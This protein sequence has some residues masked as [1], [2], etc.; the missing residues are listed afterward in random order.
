MQINVVRHR[1]FVQI[2][3]VRHRKFVQINVGFCRLL[4]QI[5]VT[6]HKIFVQINV[7]YEKEHTLTTHRVEEQVQ[8]QASDSQ[9]SKT[10]RQDLHPSSFRTNR[11]QEN[12]LLSTKFL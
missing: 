10:G 2:N 12:A 4:V 8:P 3:V 5:N 7:V 11:I 6:L 1:K 9:W